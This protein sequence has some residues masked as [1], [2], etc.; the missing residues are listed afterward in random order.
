MRNSG[1]RRGYHDTPGTTTRAYTIPNLLY[2]RCPGMS[3]IIVEKGERIVLVT[4]NHAYSQK[5]IR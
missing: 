5:N 3:R 1:R 2:L 4:M